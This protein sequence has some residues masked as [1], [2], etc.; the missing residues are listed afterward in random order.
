MIRSLEGLGLKKAKVPKD[1]A[2][3]YSRAGTDWW[4]LAETT[5]EREKSGKKHS[6]PNSAMAGY[7]HH[8]AAMKILFKN[9]CP[10]DLFYLDQPTTLK[11]AANYK[12]MVIPFAYSISKKAFNVIKNAYKNGTKLL[13]IGKKGETDEIGNKYPKPL[14]E[15]LIGKPGVKYL[16]IDLLKNGNAPETRKN[17]LAT[18][19]RLLGSNKHFFVNTHNKDV[20]VGLLINGKTW[21]IP[22]VNWH[23]KTV[24]ID[25]GLKLAAGKYKLVRYGL[26]GVS[27][28]ETKILSTKELE[29][30]S[31][32]LNAHETFIFVVTPI[33]GK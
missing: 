7:A 12:V 14:L 4:E 5:K 19:A 23:N 1:I 28:A 25:I 9:G 13:I 24:K 18:I 21:F 22:V 20:E 30:F 8:D 15:Q 31:V 11:N 2:F 10:F 29:I 6:Y 3:I 27:Q 33:T 26:N 17:I 16:D 32:G